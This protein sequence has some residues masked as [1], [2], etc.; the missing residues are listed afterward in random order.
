[1]QRQDST[2]DQLKTVYDLAN[3]AG[4]YDAAVAIK[5]TFLDPVAKKLEEAHIPESKVSIRAPFGYFASKYG[6]DEVCD[7]LGWDVYWAKE[8]KGSSDEIVSLSQEQIDKL[9]GK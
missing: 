8:G 2:Y 9:E 7:V 6:W 3:Q 4:C 5:H 1:M